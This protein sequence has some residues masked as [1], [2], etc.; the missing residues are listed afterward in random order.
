MQDN[1]R[2]SW[3]ITAANMQPKW[4]MREGLMEGR[5]NAPPGRRVGGEGA[6]DE[7]T[8]FVLQKSASVCGMYRW[9]GN[10]V[11]CISPIQ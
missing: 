3:R 5:K 6:K 1:R 10:A 8:Q 9:G 11:L 7:F 2:N 4:K